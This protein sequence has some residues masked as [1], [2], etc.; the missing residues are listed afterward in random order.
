MKEWH[1]S[2]FKRPSQQSS[3][4]WR[5]RL[6]SSVSLW[7]DLR[8]D[9]TR[10]VY[11][12]DDATDIVKEPST[13]ADDDMKGVWRSILAYGQSMERATSEPGSSRP[14][15]TELV[16][17]LRNAYE[18]P[19]P[20]ESFGNRHV[21]VEQL[22]ECF[23][24]LQDHVSKARDAL[25]EILDFLA[26]NEDG[27]DMD[28]LRKLLDEQLPKV[29]PVVLDEEAILRKQLD[30]ASEWQERLDALLENPGE[31]Q[32]NLVLAEELAREA[33]SFGVRIRGLVLLE[34]RLEKAH[35][36]QD[37]LDGWDQRGKTNTV[38]SVSALVRDASRI[39]L[40]SLRVRKLLDFNKEL[41]SWVERANIA[42]RSR[43][44]LSEIESLLHRAES[45]PLNL[46]EFSDKLHARVRLA[47]TWI[48][49]LEEEVPR[50]YRT[51]QHGDNAVDEVEWMKRMRLALAEDH[52]KTGKCSCLLDLCSEGVRIPV[53]IAAM[54]MLQIE[55]DAKNWLQKAEKW[56]PRAYETKKGKIEDLRDHLVKA[57]MLRDR[58][59]I[60]EKDQW[61]LDYEAE[62][63]AI[64]NAADKWFEEVRMMLSCLY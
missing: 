63:R 23:H 12:Y 14:S 36:L 7:G 30:M 16:N 15:L 56:I 20:E 3:S 38:K 37:R 61:E 35:Q 18:L 52:N 42:I 54:K 17:F 10:V 62:L 46:N 21:C 33:R 64:V 28:A 4:S 50:V 45:M 34:K 43:I 58:L 51:G 6:E 31:E 41:E 26:A 19:T 40:P 48:D 9:P 11:S 49:R 25:A 2:R 57:E 5:Q 13:A 29:C 53:E 24:S 22:S 44:S 32:D 27:V 47:R 55:I 59:L 1:S 60:E 39:N 8:G